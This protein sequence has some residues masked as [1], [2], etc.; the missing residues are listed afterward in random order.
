MVGLEFSCLFTAIRGRSAQF[1][2][3]HAR[4]RGMGPEVSYVPCTGRVASNVSHVRYINKNHQILDRFTKK[5]QCNTVQD[6]AGTN[7]H[8]S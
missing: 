5:L 6:N 2:F 7:V 1:S 3:G 8:M 4:E